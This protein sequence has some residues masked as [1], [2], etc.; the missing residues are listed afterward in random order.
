MKTCFLAGALFILALAAP[1][2]F[3]Q[4]TEIAQCIAT[5][6]LPGHVTIYVSQLLPTPGVS[7]ASLSG[8]WREYIQS[9]Y[10]LQTLASAAC[11]PMSAD[12]AIQRRILA[13][14][15]SA[16]QK[17]GIELVQVTWPTGQHKPASDTNPYAAPEVAGA[18]A[19]A[20]KDAAARATGRQPRASYCYS[21]DK[22]PTVYFSDPFDTADLPSASAWQTAFSKMLGEKYAY[23]G[24]ITCQNTSTILSAQSAIL[25]QREGLQGKQLVDTDWTYE[26][27]AAP[28]DST[29]PNSAH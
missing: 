10:K 1:G 3:A 15:E 4:Q 7:P 19:P 6:A 21:D 14:E 17:Q 8:S 24:T 28:A 25:E 23:K 22:K 16:W 20:R 9:T 5:S 13:T 11:R 27:P 26:A 29:T 18:A 2:A 12:P